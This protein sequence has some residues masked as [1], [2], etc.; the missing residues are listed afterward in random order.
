MRR[1]TCQGSQRVLQQLLLQ[2]LLNLPRPAADS[3]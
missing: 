2:L 3:A 1:S